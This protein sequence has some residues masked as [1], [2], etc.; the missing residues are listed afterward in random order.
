MKTDRE[1]I[2]LLVPDVE[3]DVLFTYYFLYDQT[4]VISTKGLT[5]EDREENTA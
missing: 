5:Y 3:R 4:I 1:D 2:Y